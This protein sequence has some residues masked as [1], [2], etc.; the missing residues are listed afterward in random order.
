MK[1]LSKQEYLIPVG[2]ECVVPSMLEAIG[3]FA[4]HGLLGIIKFGVAHTDDGDCLCWLLVPDKGPLLPLKAFEDNS[5]APVTDFKEIA[6]D[7]FF[8]WKGKYFQFIEDDE[9]M[10]VIKEVCCFS[11]ESNVYGYAQCKEYGEVD[12]YAAKLYKIGKRHEYLF[13]IWYLNFPDNQDYQ[14]LLVPMFLSDAAIL[15]SI[16]FNLLN[17]EFMDT[18]DKFLYEQQIWQLGEDDE[19]GLFINKLKPFKI[20]SGSQKH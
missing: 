20:I 5:D 6:I 11:T 14:N 4:E 8:I 10:F 18:G 19:N 2:N 13:P 15:N 12:I 16:D 1:P 7:S 9:L 17:W 3:T